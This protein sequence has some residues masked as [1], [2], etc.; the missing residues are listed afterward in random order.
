M[1]EYIVKIV[2]TKEYTTSVEAETEEQAKEMAIAE[3]K[4]PQKTWWIGSDVKTEIKRTKK[5]A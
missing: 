1:N 3:Y 2:E 4:N 5:S